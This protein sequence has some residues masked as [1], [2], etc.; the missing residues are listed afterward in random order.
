VQRRLPAGSPVEST[1][2]E[3]RDRLLEKWLRHGPPLARV[4]MLERPSTET[5]GRR[6]IPGRVG[7]AIPPQSR[8]A[9][10]NP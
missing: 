9:P 4:D 8:H 5:H 6:T 7:C 3:H 10:I 1:F 2:A